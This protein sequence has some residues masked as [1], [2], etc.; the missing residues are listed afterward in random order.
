MLGEAEP[1]LR[2]WAMRSLPSAVGRGRAYPQ[3]SGELEPAIRRRARRSLALEGWA[4][5]SLALG[6]RARRSLAL[7]GRARR[8][9]SSV[10]RARSV[11]AFLSDRKR[12]RSMV[13]SSTS[14][15]TM[16]LG[17]RHSS[18]PA[19]VVGADWE[20]PNGDA[21]SGRTQESGGADKA[22]RSSQ[23]TIPRTVPYTPAGQYY[24]AMSERCFATF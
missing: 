7:G 13:I 8:N 16:I 14:L 12:H 17:P 18:S 6:C 11:V 21:H 24:Q 10:V 20:R 3:M 2:H 9:Q 5:Q 23:T 19:G 4:R 1:A 22:R 15:G